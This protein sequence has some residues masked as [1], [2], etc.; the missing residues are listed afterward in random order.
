MR[1]AFVVTGMERAGAQMMLLNLVERLSRER[2]RP[3][4]ISLAGAAALSA[5]LPPMGV[6]VYHLD[7]P[8]GRVSIRALARLARILR[9]EKPDLIQ[10][11]MYHGNLAAQLAAGLIPRCPPVVWSI[12]GTHTDLLREKRL[13]ALTIWLGARLSAFPAAIIYNSR[14]S[15]EEH[16][17]RLKYR[18]EHELIIPN[19]FDTVA[20][21]PSSDA[22]TR[23]RAEL[24]VP[25][26]ALLI[27]LVARFHPVKDHATFFEALAGARRNYPQTYGVLLGSG[28]DAANPRLDALIAKTGVGSFIR[29]LG[30]RSDVARIT[31]ALDIACSSSVSE[32]FPN[33][34]GEA[35]ACG[36]PC[37]VTDVGDSAWLVGDTGRVVPPGAPTTFATA[38]TELISMSAA[39]RRSLG[40]H[41]RQRIVENFSLESV[42]GRYS[43]AYDAIIER[44]AG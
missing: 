27:G 28:T 21:Q 19:G 23:L 4:V 5:E 34:V 41:A 12:R 3:V 6:P 39:D 24:G 20:F 37:L 1:I 40:E 25:A 2:I 42:V 11:W 43:A 35:M 32:G 22:R 15:A 8:L 17:R 36:V 30:E 33:A 31:S 13:T 10:G 26:E 9:D 7:V 14:V 29:R 38:L 18:R 16:E 44:G